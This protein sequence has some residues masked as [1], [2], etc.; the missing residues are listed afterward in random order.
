MDSKTILNMKR[1]NLPNDELELLRRLSEKDLIVDPIDTQLDIVRIGLASISSLTKDSD[2]L[3]I[4][5]EGEEYL[6]NLD[7]GV[8]D[9]QEEE[10]QAEKEYRARKERRDVINMR[11]GIIASIVSFF[12]SMCIYRVYSPRAQVLIPS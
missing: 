1:L 12:C 6:Y 9:K 7:N 11:L 10:E 4:T 5:N 3:S 8:F 2:R